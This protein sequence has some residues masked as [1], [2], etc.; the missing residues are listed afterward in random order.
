MFSSKYSQSAATLQG[1]A[2]KTRH[3]VRAQKLFGLWFTPRM[4]LLS[5]M[6]L[7]NRKQNLC[8]WLAFDFLHSFLQIHF[9]FLYLSSP[10]CKHNTMLIYLTL[11]LQILAWDSIKGIHYGNYWTGENNNFLLLLH[12][13]KSITR[14]QCP[15]VQLGQICL[16]CKWSF[17]F[18]FKKY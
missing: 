15:G 14:Q 3:P 2:F 1:H 16:Y 17:S 11:W 5:S 18:T 7:S 4:Q 12:I 8:T 6:Q 9:D 10:T 13:S